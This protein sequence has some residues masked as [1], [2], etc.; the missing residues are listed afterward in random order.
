MCYV[1]IY[2]R[3]YPCI[4]FSLSIRTLSCGCNASQK[5]PKDL[6]F[7]I[8]Q[9]LGKRIV[10]GQEFRLINIVKSL[11]SEMQRTRR[12]LKLILIEI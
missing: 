11:L 6:V 10:T 12:Y 1:G 4:G 2:F 3:I 7:Q 8:L 9:T 5:L